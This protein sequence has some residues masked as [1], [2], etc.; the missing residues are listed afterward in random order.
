MPF[1]KVGPNKYKSPSGR[2]YSKKQ[3]KMYYATE[4]FKKSKI[5]GKRKK[6]KK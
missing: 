6:G 4:G 1:K 3:V 2:T 5:R